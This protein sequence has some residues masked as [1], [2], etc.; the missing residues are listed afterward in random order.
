MS[1]I[2]YQSALDIATSLNGQTTKPATLLAAA[3]KQYNRAATFVIMR[4]G[5][6]RTW[7]DVPYIETRGRYCKAM[8]TG[9]NKLRR[10]GLFTLKHL[11]TGREITGVNAKELAA[12]IKTN[13]EY[14]LQ[15][16]TNMIA[17]RTKSIAGWYLKDT[18]DRTVELQDVYGNQY[19]PMT[20]RDF[21]LTH[22]D[23]I[24]GSVGAALA[25]LS[26]KK[27]TIGG[28]ALASTKID[29]AA[30]PRGQYIKDVSVVRDGKTISASSVPK[31]AAKLHMTP[32]PLYQMV[33]GFKTEARGFELKD[34]E[35]ENKTVLTLA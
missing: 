13:H 35:I 5:D 21:V 30:R 2:S 20:I 22:G 1:S 4:G 18:L 3:C 15:A 11:D 34:V 16:V 26:G 17:G 24:G 12:K 14:A 7:T 8:K 29:A 6:P 9:W 32:A 10:D 19:A 33:Y 27:R 31:L 28:L 23:K 25:L